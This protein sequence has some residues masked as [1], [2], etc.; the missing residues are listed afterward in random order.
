MKMAQEREVLYE[1]A[2]KVILSH[3]FLFTKTFF[4]YGHYTLIFKKKTM[5][6]LIT[7]TIL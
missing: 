3:V 7:V 4:L 6:L 2:W 5:K 1:G